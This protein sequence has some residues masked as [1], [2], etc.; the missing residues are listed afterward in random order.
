VTEVSVGLLC[1]LLTTSNQFAGVF[2]G[3]YIFQP[4]IKAHFED[5]LDINGGGSSSSSGEATKKD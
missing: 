5:E 3:V 2:S 1:G 4:L